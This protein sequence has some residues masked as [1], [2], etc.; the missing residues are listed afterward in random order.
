MYIL[1]QAITDHLHSKSGLHIK[2]IFGIFGQRA[3]RTLKFISLIFK[4]KDVKT[5]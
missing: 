1:L 2:L 3:Q 5:L 4:M